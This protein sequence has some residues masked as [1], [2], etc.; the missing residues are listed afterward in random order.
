M[1][2]AVILALV[3]SLNHQDYKVREASQ[4]QLMKMGDEAAL[5]SRSIFD[6][7]T[8]DYE[9][10]RRCQIIWENYLAKK[11]LKEKLPIITFHRDF[12]AKSMYKQYSHPN[13][14]KGFALTDEYMRTSTEIWFYKEMFR[15][16]NIIQIYNDLYHMEQAE[17]NF[18][19]FLN[20]EDE[21]EP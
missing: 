4:A 13:T 8:E 15:G 11:K 2:E 20:S 10:N 9:I 3:M 5:I 19:S 12:F 14:L 16:T 7:Y 17:E 18:F 1:K 21:N 6:S